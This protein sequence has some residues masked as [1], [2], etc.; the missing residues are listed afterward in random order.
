MNCEANLA[1]NLWIVIGKENCRDEVPS[2][3]YNTY[4]VKR[5]LEKE[6][7]CGARFTF[8]RVECGAEERHRSR[9][10]RKERQTCD[11]SI[12]EGTHTPHTRTHTHTHTTL[13]ARKAIE[14][15]KRRASTSTQQ[16]NTHTCTSPGV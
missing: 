7:A 12:E 9:R 6:L 16:P 4:R 10:E 5:K 11:M 3:F 14:I 15:E 1:L 8:E 13:I 2:H